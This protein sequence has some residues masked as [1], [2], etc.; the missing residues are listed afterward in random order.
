MSLSTKQNT[1]SQTTYSVM[2]HFLT[3]QGEGH[4]T[5]RAAYFIRLGG[6]DVECW[7]CD[8]K[9]SW[10]A[11]A[12]K[13]YTT[14][15]MVSWVIHSGVT[16]CVI[17][18][19]EPAM[20]DLTSLTTRL[21]AAG[22]EIAIET[23]GAYELKGHFDWICFS[24][25]K[26]KNPVPSVY[27]QC[28]ELKVVVLNEHDLEWAETHAAKVNENCL[29]FLQPEW[30]KRN[31]VLPLIIGYIKANPRWKISLQTHKYLNIP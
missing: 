8:V 13:K 14:E 5:G 29:L 30:D 2:E 17:T 9:E 12:H 16:F 24:P 4:H 10:D 25:K 19:G 21:H 1:T 3:L 18:G 22:I 26:F 28:H 31:V 27:S 7:W 23:S 6:C 20:Y 15:E 11:N